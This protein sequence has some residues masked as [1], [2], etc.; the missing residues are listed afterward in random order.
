MK[1]P[2]NTTELR[3][4]LGMVT[5]YRDMWPRRSHILAPFTKLAGLKK[6]EKV[7]WM[8]ELDKAFTQI[9]A[10]IAQDALMTYPDHN[11][12]FDIYTDSSDY[13]LGASIMQNGRPVAYYLRKLSPAQKN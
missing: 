2:T 10:V 4:F 8:P 3:M 7:D 1:P 13:Q 12:P 11:L 6:R 9:K 5:Y